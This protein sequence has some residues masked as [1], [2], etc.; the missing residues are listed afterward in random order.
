MN[1]S[2]TERF[3]HNLMEGFIMNRR[4]FIKN[5]FWGT[6]GLAALGAVPFDAFAKKE[7]VKITILH[8]NDVH[9][10]IE[11]FPLNDPKYGGL[12][13]VS[14]RAALIKKIRQTE[15]NVL[16]LDAGDIFQGTPYYNKYGGEVELK[17]MSEMGYDAATIGNH[18]FDNGLDALYKMLPFAN[19]PLI[20]A[21]Y[22]FSDTIMSGKTIPYKTFEKQGIKIGVFGIGIELTGLVEKR[23]YGN[24]KYM[25]PIKIAAQTAHHLKHEKK[26]DLVI[27]LSHLGFKYQNK[28]ISDVVLAQQSK[29]IDLII[30]G[31]T[32]T[33]LD[34]PLFFKNSDGKEILVSQVGWAGIRLGKIDYFI[35][36]QSGKKSVIGTSLKVDGN[37]NKI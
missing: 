11:P 26:C 10:H 7:M 13:G 30:G 1:P 24:T 16:L 4:T 14:R 9:S 12:G 18:D 35:E 21:N 29:N 22:D 37:I 31:H 19:F 8:T 3:T 34:Q 32:H 27:C 28:K 20:S 6:S 36:H 25:D 23:L 15:E 2:V 5:S 33:F 17:L